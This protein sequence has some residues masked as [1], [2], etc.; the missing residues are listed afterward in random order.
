MKI[1]I[2]HIDGKLPNLALMKLARFHRDRGDEIYFARMGGVKQ[3]ARQNF[4]GSQMQIAH[5]LLEAR[6][7]DRV[8]ASAIFSFSAPRVAAFKQQ[9]PQ[10]II[11]GTY[12]ASN[13]TTV[14]DVLGIK[15]TEQ[16]DYSIYP[17]FTGSMGFTQRGCRLKCGF[18]VV[19]KKEG[20]N[21]TVQTI[22]DIWR[23]DPYPKHLHLMDND[24][25][26]Q[27]REQWEA[28]IQEIVDGGFKVCLNQ[29]IN[30]RM[31]DEAAAKAIGMIDYQNDRFDQKIMY[32][33][34][35]NLG[36]EQRFFRGVDLLAKYGTSPS[37]LRVYMLIGYDKRET[38][39]Q[40]LYRFHKMVN[41]GDIK[42]YPMIFE[43]E[44]NRSLPSETGNKKLE[45]RT[46]RDFQTYVLRHIYRSVPFDKFMPGSDHKWKPPV[47]DQLSLF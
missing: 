36:D 39:E 43:S 34:W 24:F 27:P 22:A 10:A 44:R 19:P 41:H 42:P 32:T 11:G 1:R 9:F 13:R 14:E 35:D 26:G 40:V 20:K 18:C 12:N 7:F 28:R 46:L 23:G 38:W 15:P 6:S 21:H 16:V 2:T 8:Y 47:E 25:F 17:K 45:Q 31:V 37:R 30:I 3:G 33:S 4:N 29:G 5:S